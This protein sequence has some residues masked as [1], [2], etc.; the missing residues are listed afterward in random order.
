MQLSENSVAMLSI[1]RSTLEI[2][3]ESSSVYE[4]RFRIGNLKKIQTE[5]DYLPYNVSIFKV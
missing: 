3:N 2:Y 5:V 1:D 4:F